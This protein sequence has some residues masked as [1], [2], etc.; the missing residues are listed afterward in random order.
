MPEVRRN[1]EIRIVAFAAIAG[2]HE[3]ARICARRSRAVVA[4]R[5]RSGDASVIEYSRQP[6]VR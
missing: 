5:A 6:G 1:P 3:M 4:G 2:R